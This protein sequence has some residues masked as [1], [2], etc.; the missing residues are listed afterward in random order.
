MWKKKKSLGRNA[1]G[2]KAFRTSD[3][4]DRGHK[5]VLEDHENLSSHKTPQEYVWAWAILLDS[6]EKSDPGR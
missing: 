3:G 4:G 1:T 2:P 6:K 5:D